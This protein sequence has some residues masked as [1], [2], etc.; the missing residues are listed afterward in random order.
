MSRHKIQ[1]EVLSN[2]GQTSAIVTVDY[3]FDRM[4]R[5]KPGS[6]TEDIIA[7]AQS[8]AKRKL[9]ADD[10]F[11]RV[12]TP[13]GVKMAHARYQAKSSKKTTVVSKGKK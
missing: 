8:I 4:Q 2:N 12:L 7:E 6:S 9:A 3:D 10:T 13:R 1:F 5:E 11:W